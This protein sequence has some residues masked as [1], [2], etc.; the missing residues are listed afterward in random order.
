MCEPN[1]VLVADALCLRTRRGWVF[2][3]VGLSVDPG[4]LTVITGPAGSGRTML[5]LALAGRAKPTAGTL[6][7]R[8]EDGELEYRRPWLR[9][10]IGVAGIT[11][12]AELEPDLRVV[13]HRREATLLA[14]EAIEHDW[15]AQ[16]LG[17]DVDGAGYVADLATDDATLFA[18]ALAAASRPPVLVVD[19]VD[20]HA[21]QPE[22]QRIWSGLAQL[23]E[24]GVAVIATAHS[25]QLAQRHGAA[26]CTLTNQDAEEGT[27]ASV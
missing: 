4:S 24:H 1:P 10:R 6:W 7:L 8:D 18:V 17:V 21:T 12:L 26:V 22:Q 9:R 25:A 2:R 11:G 19:D 20:A 13:D 15:A 5:L 14:G 23:A 16:A 3:E 27:N